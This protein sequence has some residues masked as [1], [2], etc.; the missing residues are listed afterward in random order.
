MKLVFFRTG[1]ARYLPENSELAFY[2]EWEPILTDWVNYMQKPGVCESVQ[3]PNHSFSWIKSTSAMVYVQAAKERQ[4]KGFDDLLLCSPE[5]YV[6]E[7]CHSSLSWFR[8]GKPG[9]PDRRLGGLDSCHRRFLEADWKQRGIAWIE[10][11]VK[12]EELLDSADWICFGGG[13]GARFWLREGVS[14]PENLFQN[15][16][17]LAYSDDFQ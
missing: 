14:F 13:T 6:V 12:A 10:E 15:Y 8:N 1:G 9:F 16:P 17:G 7:G 11:C 4:E 2:M 5:G 3:V